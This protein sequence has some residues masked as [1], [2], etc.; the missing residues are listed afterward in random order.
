MLIWVYLP[1]DGSSPKISTFHLPEKLSSIFCPMNLELHAR[2][3]VHDFWAWEMSERTNVSWAPV[4]PDPFCWSE[5]LMFLPKM[6]VLYVNSFF[7]R[8]LSKVSFLETWNAKIAETIIKKTTTAF[9]FIE[10]FKF[11]NYTFEES[12]IDI[13]K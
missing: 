2:S 7:Y 6:S 1:Q 9:V 5:V 4:I 12:I 8:R 10:F 11:K 13:L 3:Y